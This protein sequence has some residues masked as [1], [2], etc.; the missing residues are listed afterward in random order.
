MEKSLVT[1]SFDTLSKI[2]RK[3]R[4]CRTY[5]QKEGHRKDVLF[6]LFTPMNRRACA[7]FCK[8]KPHKGRDALSGHCS[9]MSV[10]KADED[11]V[12]SLDRWFESNWG[13]HLNSHNDLV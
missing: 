12:R 5:T 9:A 11:Y 7:G 3:T 13:S 4:F 2:A 8:A 10:A 6:L 1:F